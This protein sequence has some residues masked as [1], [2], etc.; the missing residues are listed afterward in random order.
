[1]TIYL[2]KLK[3]CIRCSKLGA[4][5]TFAVFPLDS[6]RWCSDKCLLLWC[7]EHD[8]NWNNEPITAIEKRKTKEVIT[9]ND[10]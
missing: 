2:M 4:P 1:M 7:Q 5:I 8:V 10:I 9:I 3:H 6:F